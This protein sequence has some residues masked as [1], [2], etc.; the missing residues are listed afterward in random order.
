[1]KQALY[2][3]FFPNILGKIIIRQVAVKNGFDVKSE[4]SPLPWKIPKQGEKYRHCSRKEVERRGEGKEK[5][6]KN[7]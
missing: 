4:N 7:V 6:L 3:L 2:E 1:M 5:L